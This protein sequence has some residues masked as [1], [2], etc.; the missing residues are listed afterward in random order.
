MGDT[1]STPDHV[2]LFGV[3]STQHGYFTASQA[4]D[5]GFGWDLLSYHTKTGRFIRA[6]RG[7][8]RLRDYPS[9]P[10][11]DV[12]SAWLAVG[13]D[14]AVVSHESA[15][16]LLELSDVIPNAVHLTVP[17]SMRHLPKLPG[18]KIHTTTRPLH[19]PDL[20]EWEGIPVT[21][22]TRT[23][24][25]ATETGTGPEQIEMAIHQA[26]AWGQTTPRLLE[27]GARQRRRYVQHWVFQAL[28][29]V[30]A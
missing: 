13:K 5:C 11:E 21:S 26:I 29:Q 7:V 14:K 23:I 16:D 30:A 17:R 15:L 8:Y 9:S 6:Y 27:E 18:V 28:G 20:T 12:V 22:V 19:P 2:C 1:T 4:R 25:D 10:R 3:A 24:L